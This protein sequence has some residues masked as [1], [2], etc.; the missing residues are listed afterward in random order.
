MTSAKAT[1]IAVVGGLMVILG[2]FFGLIAGMDNLTTSARDADGYLMFDRSMFEVPSE[3]IVI[4]EPEVLQG[5]FA[6]HASDSGV[7]MMLV[8][9]L[10]VRLRGIATDDGE[11]FIGIGPSTAVDAYLQGMTFDEIADLDLDVARGKSVECETH[12]GAGLSG[13]PGTEAFWV[14]SAEGSGLLTLDW[15]VPDGEWTAIVMNADGSSGVTADLAFG[16]KASNIAVI[17]WTRIAIGLIAVL[18][19]AIAII[20]SVRHGFIPITTETRQRP[21]HEGSNTAPTI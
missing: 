9:D 3:A 12:E 8:E 11:L 1:A 2:A 14:S 6:V 16:A 19:G 10:Q 18:G 4:S 17:G 20:Y 13:P 15:T 5:R 7:P 21:R